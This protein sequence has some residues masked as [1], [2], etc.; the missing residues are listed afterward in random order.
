MDKNLPLAFGSKHSLVALVVDG[1]QLVA[2]VIKVAERPRNLTL[3]LGSNGDSVEMTGRITSLNM[4]SSALSI[5]DMQNLTTAGEKMC[6]APGDF[7]SWKKINWTLHSKA[8]IIDID[9]ASEGPCRRKSKV[10]V[11]PL[12]GYQNQGKCMELCQKLGGRSPSVKTHESWE[13]LFREDQHISSDPR[14]L[15]DYIWLAATEGNEGSQLSRQENWP[16]GIEAQEGK[17]RDY[18]TGDLLENFTKPWFSQKGDSKEGNN[19]NCIFYSPQRFPE[20]SWQESQ[21]AG[22]NYGCPCSFKNPPNF[23]IRG[24]CP[25]SDLEIVR[26]T[27]KQLFSGPSDTFLVGAAN[28]QIRFKKI[29]AIGY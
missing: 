27:P 28:S 3:I 22:D 16:E 8:R 7:L 25:G 23:I 11:F 4:F 9:G 1:K 12:E 24:A 14:K 10:Q 21:C 13:Y 6:G 26:Y 5:A 29:S 15:P 2:N 17:W 20:S 18:Y 19:S